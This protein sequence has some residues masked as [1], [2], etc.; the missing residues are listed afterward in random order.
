MFLLVSLTTFSARQAVVKTLSIAAATD[1]RS[2]LEELKPL[3]EA[4]HPGASLQFSF[5]ASASLAVQIQQGAP[6]DLFLSADTGFPSALAEDTM[7]TYATGRLVLW[8]RNDLGV[9]TAR[10]ALRVL[11]NP[12]IKHIAIA[13]PKV[14]PHGRCAEATLRN[15]GLYETVSARLVFGEHVVQTAQDLQSGTAEAGFISLPQS[16]HPALYRAGR[17]WTVPQGMYPVLKQGGVLLKRSNQITLTAAF[18]DFLLGPEG[19][20]C[21]LKQGFGVP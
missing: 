5:G 6:F 16:R 18:R 11:L 10:D 8:V 4:Q 13:N 17:S 14:D 12:D 20:A 7:F 19:R 15:T 1:L 9:D 2:V 3:F 21:F